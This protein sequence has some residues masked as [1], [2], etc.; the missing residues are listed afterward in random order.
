MMDDAADGNRRYGK[1]QAIPTPQK[2]L[3]YL[4]LTR[5]LEKDCKYALILIDCDPAIAIFRR[6]PI[7]LPCK[8]YRAVFEKE[9]YADD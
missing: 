3:D 4:I 6:T 7:D 9:Q 2:S 1:V 5:R 8:A